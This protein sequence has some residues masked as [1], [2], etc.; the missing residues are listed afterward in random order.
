M[1]VVCVIIFLAFCYVVICH[2]LL[3]CKKKAGM[4]YGFYLF[5]CVFYIAVTLI[6]AYLTEFIDE[7]VRFFKSIYFFFHRTKYLHY[8]AS[9][10]LLFSFTFLL[11]HICNT[12]SFKYISLKTQKLYLLVF[13]TRY[14][15]LFWNSFSIYNTMMKIVF[16]SVST[17]IIWKIKNRII[18]HRTYDYR[19]RDS[20]YLSLIIIPCFILSLI[21]NVELTFFTQV[22]THSCVFHFR[23]GMQKKP[24]GVLVFM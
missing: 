22:L 20:F 7:K 13:I 23:G 1:I 24:H 6:I 19:E 16:L 5:I 4:I 10:L 21:Y 11:H 18:I 14:W 2:P 17:A 9:Q 3:C 15:D 12:K 8:M